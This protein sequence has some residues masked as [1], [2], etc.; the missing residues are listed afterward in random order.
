MADGLA[1][2][3]I[4]MHPVAVSARMMS[5]PFHPQYENVDFA[6]LPRLLQGD[7]TLMVLRDA[8]EVAVPQFGAPAAREEF[9][10]GGFSLEAFVEAHRYDYAVQ[11]R[12]FP[13]RQF[14]PCKDPPY[15]PSANR[16]SEVAL[17]QAALK[18]HRFRREGGKSAEIK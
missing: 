13:T 5:R 8:S 15:P 16:A 9:L 2:H 12:C 11:R 14:F 18:R 3:S 17:I 1:I 7:G 10:D 6:L 4:Y